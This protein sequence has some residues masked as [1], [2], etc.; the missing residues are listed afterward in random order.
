[1]VEQN[2]LRE[3]DKEEGKREEQEI[4]LQNYHDSCWRSILGLF[5]KNMW[6]HVI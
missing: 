1:M 5:N 6:T 4:D 3:E 2:L